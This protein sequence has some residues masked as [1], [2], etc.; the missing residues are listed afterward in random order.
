[1]PRRDLNQLPDDAFLW[2]FPIAPPLDEA[3][4]ARV[5]RRIDD[6]LADWSAH[7]SPID[8]ARD[9]IEGTFLIVAADPDCEKCGSSIDA[10]FRTV[11]QLEQELGVAMM[12]P[13]RIFVRHGDGRVGAMTRAEFRD[14]GD[15][16]TIVFDTTA[17]TLGELRSG[18]W[19]RRA[20]LS[21]HRDL[22]RKA[23]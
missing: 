19:E 1:M 4:E 5:L 22:L 10:L 11:R 14:R 9:L 6:F 8:G 2:I 18:G 12:D 16:H 23:V 21:W 15:A 3:K 7:G 13:N 20:E 17:Q